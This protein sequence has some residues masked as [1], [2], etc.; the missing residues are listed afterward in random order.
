[1]NRLIN[2]REGRVLV[3]EHDIFI[4]SA[5]IRYGEYSEIEAR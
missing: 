2:A 4:G 5:V 1:M 3:N